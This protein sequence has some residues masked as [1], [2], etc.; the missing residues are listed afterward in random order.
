MLDA[1]SPIHGIPNIAELKIAVSEIRLSTRSVF[2]F[3][4]PSRF[5]DLHAARSESST[6]RFG[7]GSVL[8]DKK[9]G[10]QKSR[11][12]S[13]TLR[14]NGNKIAGLIIPWCVPWRCGGMGNSEGGYR[15]HQWHMITVF[16]LCTAHARTRRLHSK[17]NPC[18]VMT[19]RTHC[20]PR[21]KLYSR[22][23]TSIATTTAIKKP[24]LDNAPP[25]QCLKG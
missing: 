17:A 1:G 23:I 7:I 11:Y 8:A 6:I 5:F 24:K 2:D 9:W 13:S 4:K 21:I 18:L 19:Y 10:R 22:R 15:K 3:H 25:P 14:R 20:L 12:D 16:H